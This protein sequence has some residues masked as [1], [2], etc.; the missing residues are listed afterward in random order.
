MSSDGHAWPRSSFSG[1]LRRFVA[2]SGSLRSRMAAKLAC[3]PLST[4][5][6][7]LGRLGGHGWPRNRLCGHFWRFVTARPSWWPPMAAKF[8][9][10]SLTAF[11]GHFQLLAVTH[12][13][14]A[15]LPATFDASWPRNRLGGHAWPRNQLVGHLRRF[16]AAKTTLAVIDDRQLVPASSVGRLADIS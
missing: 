2:A 3:R 5:R 10:Q 7:R 8:V 15:G 1:R 9:R 6:D 14:E 13:R 4:L 12:G 11:H 16:M